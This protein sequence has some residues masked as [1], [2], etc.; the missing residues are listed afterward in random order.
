LDRLVD[1][2]ERREHERF[3]ATPARVT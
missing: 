3:E 2:V 1:L